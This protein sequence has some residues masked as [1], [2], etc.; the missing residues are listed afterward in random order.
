MRRAVVTGIGMAA[1]GG[2]GR[3]EF[4]EFITSGRTATRPISLFDAALY[5]SRIA[6]EVDWDPV[7]QGFTTHE[8]DKFDR[9]VQF[10][11]VSLNEAL[12]DS[13]LN[14]DQPDPERVGVSVGTAIGCTMGLE[15]EYSAVSHH[16][17]RWLVDHTQAD[18]WCFDY[19]TPTSFA[20][21]VA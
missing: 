9:M 15:K 17:S 14:F 10:A 1:P 20:R 6:A 12:D 19:F 8:I 5:R 3:K 4:W 11:L 13:G 7:A 2:I 18:E 16:G 21:E